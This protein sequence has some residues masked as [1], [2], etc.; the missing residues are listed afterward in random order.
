MK[1][2]FLSNYFNHHQKFISEELNKIADE[3]TFVATSEMRE[4][5][6]QLGYGESFLPFYVLNLSDRSV[7]SITK[8]IEE[9]D[10]TIVGSAPSKMVKNRLRLGKLVYK[11]SERPIRK[12]VPFIKKLPKYIKWHLQFPNKSKAYLLCASAFAYSDYV[13]YGM[14]KEKA[15]KWGYF[16]ELYTYNIDDLL[17]TKIR[18]HILWCGRFLELKHPDDVILAAKRLCDEGYVF[19]ID[20][21]GSGVMED[22]LKNMVKEASLEKFVSFLG[23][24]KPNEV[25]THMEKAGIYLFTSDKNEGWG[26]VLNESMNSGCAVIASH[27]IGSV[28][29]LLE[30]NK[31]GLIYRSGDVDMLCEKIKYLLDNKKEQ[32]RLGREAYKT[33]SK[34]WNSAVAAER[35]VKLSE[36]LLLGE[37]YP[38]PYDSGPCS[39][40]EIIKDDWY[41]CR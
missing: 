36:S 28:P 25:R 29:Y 5:R 37:K 27:A 20:F 33:I 31:N 26:A 7:K 35:L 14:F 30:D 17:N 24:M 12:N 40:A 15:Y 10:L 21:I 22:V 39:K 34:E 13:K 2:S 8:V 18:T 6:K 1:I 3:Y 32:E 16:P 41:E 38:S 9:S 11:Y 4:E 19:T 23:S